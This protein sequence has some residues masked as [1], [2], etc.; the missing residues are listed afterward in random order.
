MLTPPSSKWQSATPTQVCPLHNH[1]R[2]LSSTT[3]WPGDGFTN[4]TEVRLSSPS[5]QTSV[6]NNEWG[7][8]DT[9]ALGLGTYNLSPTRRKG[10][11]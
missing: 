6:L 11:I 2:T 3:L 5:E 1:E 7:Y 9:Y 4:L 10:K 8:G